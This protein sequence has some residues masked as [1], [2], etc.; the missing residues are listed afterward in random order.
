MKASS[1]E[2]KSSYP[3]EAARYALLRRLAP[4]FRHRM[5]GG[6]HPIELIAEAAD[7]RLQA[8][9]PDLASARENLGRIKNL[10]RSA[11]LSCTNVTNWL[12]P[13]DG[14]VIML[15]EG[16]DECLALLNTDFDM[17][18]FAIC[19][20][21]REIGVDVSRTALRNV[22]TASLIAATDAAPRPADLVL[23]ADLSQ[24]HALVSI[25]VRA[26]DRDAGFADA[27]PYRSLAWSEV[28]ALAQAES[29]ELSRQGDRITMLYAL[30]GV[31]HRDTLAR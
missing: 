12:A 28:G 2:D 13:E 24:G 19:N 27:A 8:A 6:L 30:A 14:T 22:L 23:T 1:V 16:I 26:A 10:C 21:A 11:V 17:R 4:A 9:V 20:E 18:G 29:V 31:P 5:V 3:V 25:L 15:G 7:R